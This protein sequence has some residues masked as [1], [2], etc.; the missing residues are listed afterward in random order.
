MS[1][2]YDSR[3]VYEE[4]CL[5]KKSYDDYCALLPNQS[6]DLRR[7][8]EQ[9]INDP[10]DVDRFATILAIINNHQA[11][12]VNLPGPRDSAPVNFPSDTLQTP[13]NDLAQDYQPFPFEILDSGSSS[14]PHMSNP[15]EFQQRES[16][17]DSG[18]YSGLSAPTER[19]PLILAP[20]Q[21]EFSC[22]PSGLTTV[23][24]VVEDQIMQ[25]P[26]SA[27]KAGEPGLESDL[28]SDM[29]GNF[30]AE[31]FFMRWDSNVA[32]ASS[33]TNASQE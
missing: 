7:L 16:E 22:P 5:D 11:E 26:D 4:N 9:A 10:R 21:A 19:D 24:N 28:G 2:V 6:P 29:A 17:M 31:A 25:T 13:I 32:D 27:P 15:W 1:N 12:S 20:H 14:F 23:S 3:L 30:N 18:F 8:V 33:A